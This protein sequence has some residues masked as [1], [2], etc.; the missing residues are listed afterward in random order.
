MPDRQ[1]GKVEGQI[2]KAHDGKVIKRR[3]N[4]GWTV[5]GVQTRK[6]I[7]ASNLNHAKESQVLN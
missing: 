2:N 1:S 5:R 3:K 7:T 6:R 4:K